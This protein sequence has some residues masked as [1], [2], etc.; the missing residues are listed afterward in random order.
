[1]NFRRPLQI[2]FTLL[3]IFSMTAPAF[4]GDDLG[5][6]RDKFRQILNNV[7]K[8]VEKNFYDP[9]MKGVDWKVAVAESRARI[10]NAKSIGDMM[11]AVYLLTYKLHDSHTQFIPPSRGTRLFYG[12]EAKPIGDDIRIYELKKGDPAQKAGLKLGDRIVKL[13]GYAA[14]RASFDLMMM[15]MRAIRPR[16]AF[17]MEVQT[18]NDPLRRVHL[19]PRVKQGVR[20]VEADHLADI[21]DLITE[22]ENW[23]EEHK[24]RYAKF[25]DG[26]VGYLY[27]RD[28]PEDEAD[29]LRGLLDQ[30]K[31]AKA[32]IV[33]LRSN[34]GG[35]LECLKGV[36]GSFT[37]TETTV[38][39]MVS[40]KKT[41][42]LIIKPKRPDYS[43]S[44][45]Y[46]LVDS[47]TGSAAEIFARYFQRTGRAVIVGDK[48]SGR[49]TVS[50]V[51]STELGAYNAILYA[52]QIGVARAVFPDNEEIEGK[53]ITPD[54]YCIP[55]GDQ[56]RLQDDA[57]LAKTIGLAKE[58]LGIKSKGS[59]Q[60]KT[61]GASADE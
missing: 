53:G 6:E 22:S 35:E 18:G 50:R 48:S 61:T 56:M 7:A 55:T 19:E 37:P 38:L 5:V 60:L 9:S 29:F 31:G 58:K 51:F 24:F 42:P 59:E 27:I 25:A 41:E 46:I 33:D 15:D 12:F 11:L 45:L 23:L 34:P 52:T 1:M 17:D 8:D 43:S 54:V 44:P 36:M 28:F 21:W 39:N 30:L 10:D 4:A 3:V 40:R 16:T 26:N 2:A 20:V 13:N 14:D 57:C 32:V 49:V 47:E